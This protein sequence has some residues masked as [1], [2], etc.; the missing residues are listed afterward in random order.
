MRSKFDSNDYSDVEVGDEVVGGGHDI[1]SDKSDSE[2]L[3]TTQEQP[4]T[5]DQEVENESTVCVC[6]CV[7]VCVWILDMYDL[8]FIR[9][10]IS[11]FLMIAHMKYDSTEGILLYQLGGG[12]K[13][14]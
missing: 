10:V 6:V 7:C 2:K 9:N 11:S 13:N 14:K 1:F 8:V 5:E 12:K 4:N 3:V